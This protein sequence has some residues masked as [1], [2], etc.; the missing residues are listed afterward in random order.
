MTMMLISNHSQEKVRCN[1]T[2]RCYLFPVDGKTIFTTFDA[3]IQIVCDY[4]GIT[5][6]LTKLGHP[7]SILDHRGSIVCGRL[8][9]QE[10]RQKEVSNYYLGSTQFEP[11]PY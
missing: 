5:I 3:I 1:Y 10:R 9:N 4:C 2:A 6:T 11:T 8:A 7:R